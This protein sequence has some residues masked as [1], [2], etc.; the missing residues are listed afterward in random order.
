MDHRVEFSKWWINEFKSVKFPSCGSV[1]DF[2]ID[3]ET[4]EFQ[5][6]TEKV[7]RF[8][9]DPDMPLQVSYETKLLLF[10]LLNYFIVKS[11]FFLKKKAVLVYSAESIRVRY[12][13]DLLMENRH[14]IMLVGNAGVGKTV[15]IADKLSSLSEQH[16]IT[17]IPFNF[18][19]TSG[20]VLFYKNLL[21]FFFTS[22]KIFNSL[23]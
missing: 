15:L 3:S 20:K 13:I 23:C 12:F 1:F 14:P 11:M 22:Y 18:Y 10:I 5:L 4:K 21:H 2:Y 6:W 16:A 7:P 17:N 19:T 8:E 9:L